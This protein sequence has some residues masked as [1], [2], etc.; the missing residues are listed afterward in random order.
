LLDGRLR[1]MNTIGSTDRPLSLPLTAQA[2]N[3][4]AYTTN[5]LDSCSRL[6]AAAVSLGNQ[7]KT[8]LASDTVVSGSA[9]TLANG[10]GMLTL[11]KPA[12]GH[13]GTVD[14]ALSLGSTAT[15]NSCL[16]SWTPSPVA[17]AGANLA[18]LRG[19]WCGAGSLR[20]PSARA[21]FGLYRGAD[22]F[23]Y[24]RENY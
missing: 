23:L 2:W 12:A 1:L 5:V 16:Q 14:V 24:Q 13:R 18:Y 8:L 22:N 20:D 17:S 10:Q 15:D 9:V 11:A 6:P 7:R 21:T 19:T 3:G 4:S